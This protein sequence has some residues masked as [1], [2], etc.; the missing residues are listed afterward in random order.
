[1]SGY[2]GIKLKDQETCYKIRRQYRH[3]TSL[4]WTCDHLSA[5]CP[6]PWIRGHTPALLHSRP[7]WCHLLS[8]L[9][10]S[11]FHRHCPP[12][13]QQLL[14][15]PGSC[16]KG[17]SSHSSTGASQWQPGKTAPCDGIRPMPDTHS[18]TLPEGK[19]HSESMNVSIFNLSASKKKK[20]K[21]ASFHFWN[22]T[23]M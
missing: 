18:C 23:L 8:S 6:L 21:G 13:F 3:H 17:F 9:L 20:K 16:Q 4:L 1:M 22:N 14:W 12:S 7:A 19:V 10:L 11:W 2:S 5:S 15:A